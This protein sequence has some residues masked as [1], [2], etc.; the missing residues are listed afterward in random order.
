M[1]KSLAVTLAQFAAVT[2]LLA[3]LV[4]SPDL[5]EIFS[6]QVMQDLGSDNNAVSVLALLAYPSERTELAEI[7]AVRAWASALNGVLLLGDPMPN[8]DGSMTM[9]RLSAIRRLP[10]GGLFEAYTW[11]AR[12]TVPQSTPVLTA[13]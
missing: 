10:T 4:T 6:T 5:P 1:S 13:V 2:N 7:D 11:I 8:V 3:E 9:R 12:T